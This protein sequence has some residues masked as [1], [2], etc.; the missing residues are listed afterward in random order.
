[1]KMHAAVF[2]MDGTLSD[3]KDQAL[4][5]AVLGLTDF[6][7]ELGRPPRIPS[8]A[9]VEPLIGM[10]SLDYFRAL[11]PSDLHVHAERIRA[12]VGGY[13]VAH[14]RAG[15]G[16]LYPGAL[17]LLA[18]LRAR[19]WGLALVSN[20]GRPYFEASLDGLALREPFDVRLCLDDGP[21]GTTKT[22]LVR[23]ALRRLGSSTGSIVGDRKYD[24]EAGRAN[25]LSTIAVT[26]GFGRPGELATADH[27]AASLA[28]V[29]RLL[30][31]GAGNGTP[32]VFAVEKKTTL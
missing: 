6:Y 28:D 31:G 20:C 14:L 19:G 9:E 8:P 2:D 7:R 1:M 27:H 30:L 32:Q 21:S 10:P 24:L 11:V 15:R 4:E 17:E 26:Y 23:E 3:S 16:R 22:D 29:G 13:E 18:A 12:L 25:G 5:A